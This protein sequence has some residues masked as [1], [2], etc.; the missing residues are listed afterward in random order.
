MNL[1]LRKIPA[2]YINLQRDNEKNEYMHNMLTELEFET[3]IRV[4]ASEFPDRHLAGCS[5]CLA[6]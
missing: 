4:E 3:I 1:D 5:L 2:I 6:G